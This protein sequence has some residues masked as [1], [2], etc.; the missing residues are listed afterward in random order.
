MN[1]S[2]ETQHVS[3]LNSIT[4]NLDAGKQADI[5]LLIFPKH[6]ESCPYVPL[7]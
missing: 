2:C 4:E 5:M 3:T 6:L 7:S 1:R